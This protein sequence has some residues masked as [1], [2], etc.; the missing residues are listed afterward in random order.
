MRWGVVQED[1]MNRRNFLTRGGL[2]GFV[3]AVP[4]IFAQSAIEVASPLNELYALLRLFRDE[5]HRCFLHRCH[6]GRR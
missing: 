4:A 2:L 6:G 5:F 1:I 3:G